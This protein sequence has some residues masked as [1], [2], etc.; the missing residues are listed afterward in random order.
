MLK[1]DP[2]GVPDNLDEYDGLL[3]GR[4]AYHHIPGRHNRIEFLRDCRNHLVS[5]APVFIDDFHTLPN[6]SVR[7][8]L[9]TSIARCARWIGGCERRI[10]VGDQLNAENFF[11][12]FQAHEIDAELSAADYELI[13]VTETPWEGANLA[14]AVARVADQSGNR[15][16]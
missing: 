13:S 3:V 10:E 15:A 12:R 6:I 4:G 11:H 14:Y 2:D 1:A 8:K 7:D 5:N 9:R 16:S